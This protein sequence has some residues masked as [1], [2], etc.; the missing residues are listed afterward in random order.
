MDG[1]LVGNVFWSNM[2]IAENFLKL[3]FFCAC[4]FVP[5]RKLAL[6]WR[7][8]WTRSLAHTLWMWPVVLSFVVKYSAQRMAAACGRRITQKPSCISVLPASL[9]RSIMSPLAL[10]WLA[11]C[12]WKIKSRWPKNSHVNATMAGKDCI[13]RRSQSTMRYSVLT[14]MIYN[15][16]QQEKL[17]LQN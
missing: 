15:T 4:F 10:F 16:C 5:Y 3:I 11:R 14:F 6:K 8:M 1:T 12:Q 9:L 7:S 13:V 17:N 2:I